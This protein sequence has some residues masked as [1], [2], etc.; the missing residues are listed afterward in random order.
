MELKVIKE[1]IYLL[2]RFS[3][4]CAL[5][6]SV[7][8][9]TVS[10]PLAALTAHAADT[11]TC[12]LSVGTAS[13]KPGE[14]VDVTVSAVATDVIASGDLILYYDASVLEVESLEELDLTSGSAVAAGNFEEPGVIM[15]AFANNSFSKTEG[16]LWSIHFKIKEAASS[17]VSNVTIDLTDTLVTSIT[18]EAND[19]RAVSFL[20]V[21]E[22][23]SVMITNGVDE[24]I[25]LINA[26][27]K[28]IT[29]GSEA[30]IAQAR[31]AYDALPDDQK[32]LVD[33][34]TLAKLTKAEAVLAGLKDQAAA[35]AVAEQIAA[36]PTEQITFANQA[37]IRA[38]YA[39]FAALTE[40]Q[41][42]LLG[43]ELI[44]NLESARQT[45]NSLY[46]DVNEDG[47]INAI[48]AL[49]VLQHS[50]KLIELVDDQ[51]MAADV[52]ASDRVN[53][54]DALYILMYSVIQTDRFPAQ[55]A[56]A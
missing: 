53:S 11:A 24:V 9:L 2:K 27:E 35:D 1:L 49:M 29:L 51:F 36:L 12:T 18:G 41:K 14:S 10:T 22:D 44:A 19:A 7:L 39:S 25:S 26:L 33:A 20:L 6:L 38:A 13:G 56:A 31:A 3:K 40:E 32:V 48:D 16:Q 4:L 5:L 17:S 21:A 28:E 23:G 34:D 50:V 43:E 42:A 45:L 52:D 55:I 15:L 47:S 37:E 54:T 8:V 30:A 46:G